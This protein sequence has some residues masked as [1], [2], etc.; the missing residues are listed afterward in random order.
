MVEMYAYETMSAII[1]RHTV[2]MISIMYLI[3][4]DDPY[5]VYLQY[6]SPLSLILSLTL[7]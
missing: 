6:A 1:S 3:Q 2:R 5:A 7:R 4:E